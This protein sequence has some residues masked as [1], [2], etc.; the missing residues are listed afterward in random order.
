MDH[1]NLIVKINLFNEISITILCI[2]KLKKKVEI[3]G[4]LW[5]AFNLL[6]KEKSEYIQG[7]YGENK[8]LMLKIF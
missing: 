1:V 7:N 3:K 5:N 6:W 8:E 2:T 4:K